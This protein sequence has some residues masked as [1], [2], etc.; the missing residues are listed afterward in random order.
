MNSFA[1]LILGV[2][3]IL[4]SVLMIYLRLAPKLGLFDTP[5]NRSSHKEVT[6]RGAGIIY[7]IAL[8]IYGF[9]YDFVPLPLIVGGLFLGVV[10]FIDDWKNLTARLRLILHAGVISW[11]ISDLMW[12][13]QLFWLIPLITFVY[14]WLMNAYNFMDGINGMTALNSLSVLLALLLLNIDKP[15]T[16]SFLLFVLILATVIFSFFNLRKKAICFLGDVGSIPLG[17]VLIG[18]TLGAINSSGDTN[19]LVFF[20]VYIIDSGWTIFQRLIAKENI[21]KPHRKHLY[22]VLVNE[23]GFGHL[24]VSVAYFAI[25][26]GINGLYFAIDWPEHIFLIATFIFLSVAYGLIKSRLLK[27]V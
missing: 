23:K 22:Q 12:G 8:V 5:N 9:L 27:S 2:F 4:L 16:N 21:L 11:C 26:M 17:F 24:T 25:Q 20:V 13:N 10:S 15:F 18:L 6:I 3:G 19:P 1:M 7:P 14:L